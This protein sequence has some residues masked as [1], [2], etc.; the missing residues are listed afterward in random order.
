MSDEDIV[1]EDTPA[2]APEAKAIVEHFE[3]P[4]AEAVKP[5]E[6]MPT[7]GPA[8]VDALEET[9]LAYKEVCEPLMREMYTVVEKRKRLE[10]YEG[11]LKSEFERLVGKDRGMIQRGEYGAKV[12]D[13]KG[14][15]K[16]DWERFVACVK[17]WAH[18]HMG[19]A[20]KADIE[21]MLKDNRWPGTPSIA[22]TPYK[23]GKDDPP[24]D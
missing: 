15:D 12:L 16:T 20:G 22:I 23:V 11:E 19:D 2:L 8:D 13:R 18:H 14:A 24:S 5:Q 6:D 1:F 21:K 17:E 10:K 7:F 3:K 9:P 4:I